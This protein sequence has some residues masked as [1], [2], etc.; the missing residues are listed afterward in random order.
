MRLS[1][2]ESYFVRQL[3]DA[4]QQHEYRYTEA[5]QV[6]L[7]RDLFVA[8][9]GNNPAYIKLLFPRGLP[10]DSKAESWTLS[11]AQGALEGAEYSAAARGKP[12][13]HI[14]K[15]GEATYKCK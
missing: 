11:G 10:T 8:L 13:G 12:C 6:A 3:R 15:S 9:V 2:S 5:A 7:L 4:P 14:F 1:E